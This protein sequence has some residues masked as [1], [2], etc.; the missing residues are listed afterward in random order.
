[1]INYNYNLTKKSEQIRLSAWRQWNVFRFVCRARYFTLHY[2]PTGPSTC[3]TTNSVGIQD[4]FW[5][6]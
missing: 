4:S 2:L 1:M 6:S 3:P 5:R